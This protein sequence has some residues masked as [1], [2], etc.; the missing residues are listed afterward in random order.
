MFDD[1]GNDTVRSAIKAQPVPRE[2][3]STTDT[4]LDQPPESETETV[5][6]P[7]RRPDP[8]D[9][10]TLFPPRISVAGACMILDRIQKFGVVG[11][12]FLSFVIFGTVATARYG[13]PAAQALLDRERAVTAAIERLS[14]NDADRQRMDQVLV[15]L[16]KEVKEMRRERAQQ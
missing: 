3:L 8:L 13:D 5:D 16:V 6:M 10:I 1:S 7:P 2:W 12:A 15:D 11:L 9:M 14:A 4:P